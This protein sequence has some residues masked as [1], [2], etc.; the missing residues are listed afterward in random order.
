LTLAIV[1]MVFPAGRSE[2]P[3]HKLSAVAGSLAL[4]SIKRGA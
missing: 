3:E 2:S 1:V 4:I